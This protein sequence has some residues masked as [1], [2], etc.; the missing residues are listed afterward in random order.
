[1]QNSTV[2][3]II[4]VYNVFPYVRESITSAIQQ[5]YPRLEIIVIDDGSTDGSGE[6]CDEIAMMDGRITV[7]HTENRGLSAARNTGLKMMTGDVVAFLDSDDA[8]MPDTIEK[9]L[10]AMI[11][12][13]AEIVSF[14]FISLRTKGLLKEADRKKQK[15]SLCIPPAGWYRPD[16]WLR[17]LI[18]GR[19]F[20]VA[21]WC[22]ISRTSLWKNIA[23]PEGYVYEDNY[24]VPEIVKRS[25]SIAS[26]SEIFV[27][28]RRR[29]GSNR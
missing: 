13:D 15:V 10:H 12:K 22:M 21:V 26:L 8:F 16:E 9:A 2:S 29:K 6:I 25:G 24:V 27:L 19:Q 1:M 14:G 18:Q 28:N 4:P 11:D 5:T 3:I 20:C 7:V 17:S 23:F